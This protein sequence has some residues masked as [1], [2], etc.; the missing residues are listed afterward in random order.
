MAER[1]E[2]LNLPNAVITRIIKE[3]LPE[4]VNISKEARSA[5][6]RAASVFVLYATS[7]ANNFAVKGKRKTLNAGDVL[8]AMEEMEFQRFIAPLKESLEVYRREQKGKK[9]ARKDKKADSEEQ[10]KS[11]EEENDEDDER[12][13]EEE[14]NDDEEV[15]N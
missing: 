3:A 10:D 15:D 6:S 12:M 9:E 8:S 1:P 2:D 7:C 5:I 11:R 13:E 14:Q 4:G